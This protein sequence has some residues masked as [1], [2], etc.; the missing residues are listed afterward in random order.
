MGAAS[1]TGDG[2]ERFSD[3][4]GVDCCGLGSKVKAVS[5]PSPVGCVTSSATS[6]M[7]GMGGRTG[8]VCEM[9]DDA[10]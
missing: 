3:E 1:R 2:V 9:G 5:R 6:A 8:A 4:E 10:G 7:L